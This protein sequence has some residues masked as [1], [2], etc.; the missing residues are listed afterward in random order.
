[1]RGDG[2]RGRKA[3]WGPREP[4]PTQP[5]PRS[6]EEVR[7]WPHVGRSPP[8]P[9]VSNGSTSSS[10]SG[11]SSAIRSSSSGS[12]SATGNLGGFAVGSTASGTAVGTG[13]RPAPERPGRWSVR[14]LTE[15]PGNPAVKVQQ[16]SDPQAVQPGR[17]GRDF[18]PG[19]EQTPAGFAC[20]LGLTRH[21]VAG[22]ENSARDPSVNSSRRVA[23][24]GGL[25]QVGLQ[26]LPR[27]REFLPGVPDELVG[28][29]SNSSS[30]R[31]YASRR[32]G[33]PSPRPSTAGSGGCSR[34]GRECVVEG[35][36]G[37]AGRHVNVNDER[38]LVHGREPPPG[39]AD[40]V[41]QVV[42]EAR[43]RPTG[44]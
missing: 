31:R 34:T 10:S 41:G 4:C 43:S 8:F 13:T 11:T 27:V 28:G 38:P 22:V 44:W 9:L 6:E 19:E 24:P 36:V 37:Q 15:L 33:F 18:R 29:P 42:G 40:V 30:R 26:V 16:G 14:S 25:A 39:L 35:Q 20:L 2:S 5:S 17:L 1:M 12:G 32:S 3:R 7:H 23:D 21:S